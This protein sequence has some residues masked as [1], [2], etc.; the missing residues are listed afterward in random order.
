MQDDWEGRWNQ[1]IFPTIYTDITFLQV[2]KQWKKTHEIHR[3]WRSSFQQVL[4]GRVRS[5]LG[6]HAWIPV[7][8]KTHRKSPKFSASNFWALL[9]LTIEER[10][11][12]WST[13]DWLRQSDTFAPRGFSAC[14]RSSYLRSVCPEP[15]TR[16]LWVLGNCHLAWLWCFILALYLLFRKC[17]SLKYMFQ[18][19]IGYGTYVGILL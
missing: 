13:S 9:S 11:T 7:P 1:L 12:T 6:Y 17:A 16:W 19:Y 15:S 14:C 2:L 3:N 4:A 8:A 5:G 18:Q 10:R